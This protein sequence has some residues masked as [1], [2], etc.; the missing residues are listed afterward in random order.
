[1]S[2]RRNQGISSLF[3]TSCEVATL[4]VQFPMDW[5]TMVPTFTRLP[6]ALGLLMTSPPPHVSAGQAW[7]QLLTVGSL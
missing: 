1:M 2:R 3:S 6:W 4:A 7:E 5:P